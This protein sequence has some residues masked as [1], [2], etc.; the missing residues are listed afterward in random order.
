M[1]DLFDHVVIAGY[2]GQFLVLLRLHFQNIDG[3]FL[4]PDQYD[5]AFALVLDRIEQFVFLL[6]SILVD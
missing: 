6:L 2:K 4:V 1:I 3:F 5:I